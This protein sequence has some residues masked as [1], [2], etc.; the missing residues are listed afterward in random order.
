V[1]GVQT[2][3]LPISNAK[4]AALIHL[5]FNLFG[6]LIYFVILMLWRSFMDTTLVRWFPGAYGTQLAMFHT[7]FN[8]TC[9]LIFLPFVN[10]FVKVSK[11]LI[12]D[13]ATDAKLEVMYID[14]RFLAT[15]SIAIS[16]SKKEAKRIGDI[17]MKACE[18]A[19]DGFL[20]ADN[21][22][23]GDVAELLQQMAVLNKTLTKYM[24]SISSLAVSETDEQK[25]SGLYYVL[26]D[27]LRIGDLSHNIT[28][29]TAKVASGEVAFSEGALAEIK[30]MY[31]KIKV[32][33]DECMQCYL[34]R[35]KAMYITAMKHED[36][37][38][39]IKRQLVRNHID[40]LNRG[41]CDPASSSV[42]VNLVGNIERMA[43]HMTFIAERS[44]ENNPRGSRGSATK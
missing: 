15:P 22:K 3:A 41:E 35:D 2:C 37:I 13:K 27:L 19:I 5:L 32:L 8:V 36:E 6:S 38:D 30:T 7:F 31:D 24:V 10:L 12:P 33:Y 11:I 14:N 18:T 39:E 9:T 40:R 1:T 20:H 29:Y 4:R 34:T 23:E 42:F 16:Q 21:S 28:K 26:G 44:I 25:I 17:A 43:D